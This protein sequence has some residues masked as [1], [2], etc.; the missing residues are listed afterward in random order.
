MSKRKAKSTST[1][2]F[3]SPG[4]ISHDSSPFYN[5]KLYRDRLAKDQVEHIENSVP[6]DVVDRLFLKSSEDMSE[7]PDHSVHLMVTSPPS[8]RLA[9]AT[10]LI[11][12]DLASH[13]EAY[14]EHVFNKESMQWE[15]RFAA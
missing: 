8:C 14:A 9:G 1:S 10:G 6:E 5:S 15:I 4:R 11:P 12:N 3:G 13:Q 2:S 7:L